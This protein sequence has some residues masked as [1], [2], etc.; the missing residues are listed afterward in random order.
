M[1]EGG[2]KGERDP[3]ALCRDWLDEGVEVYVLI[4]RREGDLGGRVKNQE[5][6]E[7]VAKCWGGSL[8]GG[9]GGGREG[10]DGGKASRRTGE[11][12]GQVRRAL[13]G[14]RVGAR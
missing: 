11:T 2:K 14:G 10:R 8:G 1:E 6:T 12:A 4:G 7:G 13:R 3:S 9:R 5:V